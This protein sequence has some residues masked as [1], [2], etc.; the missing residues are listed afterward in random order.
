MKFILFICTGFLLYIGNQ[1][2]SLKAAESDTA[3]FEPKLIKI[4]DSYYSTENLDFDVASTENDTKSDP[5]SDEEL[6]VYKPAYQ[7]PP[8]T[9]YIPDDNP[10]TWDEDPDNS[11]LHTPDTYVNVEGFEVQ[12]PTF[13][14]KIPEGACAVCRDGTY[15]FSRNRR[16]TCSRH[17]GVAEW[18]VQ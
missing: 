15:S 18:V 5:E 17:G 9:V 8:E 1:D 7:S 6:P 10:N 2:H 4:F 11:P 3:A 13:Y 12:S 16:G 14:H